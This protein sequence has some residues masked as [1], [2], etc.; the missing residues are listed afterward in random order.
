MSRRARGF[1]VWA[2]LRSLGADGVC[3]LIDGLCDR[4]G[5]LAAGLA[6]IPGVEVVNDVVFTQV[7]VAF[8]DDE[9]TR[10]IGAA[11]VAEGT[12]VLTPATW[13]GRGVLRCAV[14][15]WATTPA[16]VERTV[17]AVRRLCAAEGLTS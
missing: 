7:M 2:A 3:A 6:S 11:L 4:A 13:R 12:A 15:N 14:S 8:G 16:D 10:Q 9:R 17:A 5:Q 1:P